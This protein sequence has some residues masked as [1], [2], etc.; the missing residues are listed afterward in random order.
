MTAP[1]LDIRDLRLGVAAGGA[2]PR[3]LL[4]GVSFQIMPGEAYG[5][6]GE[7]GSGKS[8]TSLAVMGLLKKPLAV[9]ETHLAADGHVAGG[10]FTVADLGLAEIVRYVQGHPR[11]LADFPNVRDW[12][13]RCQARPGFKAMWETRN[14]E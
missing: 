2:A 10:R 11:L 14:A 6:V 4:K 13:A 7:S 1:L 12:L 5:L 3:P 9:F 8:L